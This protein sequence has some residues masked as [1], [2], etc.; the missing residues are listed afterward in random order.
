MPRKIPIGVDDFAEL[1]AKQTHFLFIDKTLFIKEL[2]EKG[3]KV[4]LIIRPRRWGKTLNMS[5]LRYFFASEVNGHSTQGLFDHL[6]LGQAT[7]K[8]IINQYQGKHPVI[9]IS[10]KNI[11]QDS[12]SLFF[13]KMLDLIASSYREHEKVLLESTKLLDSQKTLYKNMISGQGNQAQLENA[14]KFL[15][16]CLYKHYNQK[17]V[18]LID[19]YDTPLNAAYDKDYFEQMV[20]F[21]KS[22]FGAALKGNDALEKGLMTGI[23]RLSKNKMLS[24]INNLKL[25]SLLEDQYSTCFGFSE[26]EVLFLL[27]ESGVKRSIQEIQHW[28][29]GYCSGHAEAI[30]NPWS[31]LNCIDDQGALKPYWIKTGDEV[32]LKQ[33][34]LRSSNAVKEKLHT[35]IAGGSIESII[36]EYLSFDQIKEGDDHIIWSLLWA[37]GYLKAVGKPTLVGSLYK[38][39]LKIP[40]YEVDCSYREVFQTFLR[41]LPQAPQYDDFLKK[42][43]SGDVL[44]F[45]QGLEHF[46]VS[47]TSYYDFSH[48]SNYHIL[49][50]SLTTS[51]RDTHTIHSNQEQGLGRPDLVLIPKDPHNHLG[52][53]LEFK[54]ADSGKKSAYYEDMALDGLNQINQKKYD[55]Q[56]KTIPQIKRI[57][58]LSI[59]FY[60]KQ[61]VYKSS[62][63]NI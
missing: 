37:L 15:S 29:N 2:V 45:I 19:E 6:K 11:K 38:Y 7:H 44:G 53:I 40:N 28:Y 50:L 34:F 14:L 17:V 5:M 41:S 62:T 46:L 21:F 47:T 56:L 43:V 55:T 4:S 26:E 18:I 42:L 49:M 3:A 24:D 51:L 36:D 63:E 48:E 61:L 33:V 57:L 16:D 35:L 59:V 27:S 23:L 60:A 52:I 25:Y 13:E 10:L 58:K 12:W 9:F 54:R 32:L 39:Q 22:L 8:A 1:V 31:V 30:Y 20:D